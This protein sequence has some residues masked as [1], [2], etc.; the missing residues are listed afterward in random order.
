[1][2]YFTYDT[3]VIISKSLIIYTDKASNFVMSSVVLLELMASASDDSSRKLIER[4]FRDYAQDNSLIVPNEDDWLLASKVLYWLAQNRRRVSGGRLP[5]L[6]PGVS[7]RLALDALI[8]TRARRWKAEVVT[9]NWNDFA[10]IRRFCNVKI[11]KASEF[12]K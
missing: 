8:A 11:V 1:M 9:D 2:P 3:S 7:Q 4:L 12:F 5:R 10:A 6:A